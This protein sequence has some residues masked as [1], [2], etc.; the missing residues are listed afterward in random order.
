MISSACSIRPRGTWEKGAAHG[1]SRWG[2]ERVVPSRSN[3]DALQKKREGGADSLQAPWSLVHP[4]GEKVNCRRATSRMRKK[5]RNPAS[6]ESS[7]LREK[8]K[9]GLPDGALVFFN[10]LG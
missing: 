5:N 2:E 4:E 1:G 8:A 7:G 6:K 10:K 9:G 3:P